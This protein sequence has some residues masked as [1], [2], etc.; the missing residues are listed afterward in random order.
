MMFF[1]PGVFRADFE[2]LQQEKRGSGTQ[3]VS[4]G[5]EI[6]RYHSARFSFSRDDSA[7][8]DVRRKSAISRLCGPGNYGPERNT[9]GTLLLR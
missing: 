9:D 3:Q 6:G 4:G 2:Q 7:A 8:L 5:A 1:F